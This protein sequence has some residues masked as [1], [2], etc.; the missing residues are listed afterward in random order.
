MTSSI[1][2]TDLVFIGTGTL[3]A[4]RYITEIL[5]DHVVPYVPSIGEN[6][7][8]MH[9]NARPHVAKHRQIVFGRC[10][11]SVYVNWPAKS[12]DLNPI[13]ITHVA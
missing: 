11:H 2:R 7:H 6:F 9:D 8:L 1:A 5:E 12:P 10:R 4:S 3:T 13:D